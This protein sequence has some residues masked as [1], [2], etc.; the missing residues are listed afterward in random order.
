MNKHKKYFILFGI[1]LIFYL[2]ISII[3][4]IS[5][6]SASIITS[7]LFIYN[8]FLF[9]IFSFLIS[10]K[11]KS[12]GIFIGLKLSSII[13]IIFLLLTLLFKL[14]FNIKN[15]IYYL[16][17]ILTSTFGSITSKNTRNELKS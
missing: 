3:H 13:I 15:I 1:T 5:N 12:K 7:I 4:F 6:I 16:L 10:K 11:S 8:L 2:L 14:D 17:I 9:F